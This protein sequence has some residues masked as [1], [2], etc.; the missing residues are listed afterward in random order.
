[1]MVPPISSIIM[2][3][4]VTTKPKARSAV[5]RSWVFRAPNFSI[6]RSSRTKD[7]TTRMAFR[8]SC[9]T[10]FTASVLF[11]SAVKKGPTY[12]TTISTS[13]TRM[14]MLTRY[15]WLSCRLV[16][17]ASTMAVI[18]ITGAR[19]V[20]RMPINSIICTADTSLVSRVMRLAVEKCSMLAKLKRCTCSYS[21]PRMLAP[22]PMA[23]LAANT[24]APMPPARASSER[25]TIFT[26]VASM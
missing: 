6:S 14:G 15:T 21:A 23:A 17:R 1:M 13:T 4:K 24:A 7:F 11:C 18:S 20:M 19:T 22:K 16:R 2:G 10:R 12:R 9:T 3:M 8:S 25:I 5:S 26:P